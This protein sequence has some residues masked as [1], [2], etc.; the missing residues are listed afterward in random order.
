MPLPIRRILLLR[1][2]QRE[3]FKPRS[4]QMHQDINFEIGLPNVPNTANALGRLK[5]FSLPE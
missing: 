4:I 3:N 1:L 5:R 2:L